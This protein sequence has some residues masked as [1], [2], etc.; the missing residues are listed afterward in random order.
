MTLQIV[1]A[2]PPNYPELCKA[3]D[4]ANRRGVIFCFGPTL[5]N[6]DGVDLDAAILAHEELHS[7]RQAAF[8]GVD[9]W[10]RRY[11]DD[12]RFRFDEE[13]PAWS[14][15]YHLTAKD[16]PNR[17][18]RQRLLMHYAKVLSGPM[19]DCGLPRERV[20]RLIRETAAGF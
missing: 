19:Y 13:V 9:L 15:Q 17:Q 2:L 18:Q 12:R 16:I 3:F 10:W 4:I 11:L 5:Y 6:P 20:K 7:A 14:L 8:G 1:K